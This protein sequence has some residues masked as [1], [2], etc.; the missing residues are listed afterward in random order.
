[1]KLKQ[2]KVLK[3]HSESFHTGNLRTLND[4]KKTGWSGAILN[5]S[6]IKS[7]LCSVKLNREERVKISISH[8]PNL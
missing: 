2:D 3:L 6:G 5:D 1:M 4:K 7:S 8:M